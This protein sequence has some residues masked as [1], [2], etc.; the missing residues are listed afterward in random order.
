MNFDA[1]RT[2]LDNFNNEIADMVRLPPVA[3]SH[4]IGD[5]EEDSLFL[6]GIVGGKDVG[7]TSMINQLA[8]AKISVDTDILDEG[9]NVAVAYC[10]RKDHAKLEKR[11]A[12]KSGERIRF[13]DH[14]R[15]ELENVVLIDLPDFDS[16]F[17]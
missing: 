11:F 6:Y 7:K 2:Q 1:L 9:T 14:D 3:L 5:A 8:G 4:Q 17:L 16:R 12:L 15:K 10:H 13:V